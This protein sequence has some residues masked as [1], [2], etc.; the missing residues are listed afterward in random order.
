M[1]RPT[2]ID[3]ANETGAPNQSLAV[4]YWPEDGRLHVCSDTYERPWSASQTIRL[5]LA[6]AR[7][8]RDALIEACEAAT[9]KTADGTVT[10]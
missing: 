5:D 1:N 8:L 2:R 6:T 9:P 10:S 7:A 3:V 4:Y